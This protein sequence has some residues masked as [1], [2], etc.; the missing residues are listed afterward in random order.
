[1]AADRLAQARIEL[2]ERGLEEA[3]AL[4]LSN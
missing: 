2:K 4:K 1:M 3:R